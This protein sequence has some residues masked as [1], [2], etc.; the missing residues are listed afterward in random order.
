MKPIVTAHSKLK[1]LVLLALCVSAAMALTAQTLTTIHDIAHV[2]QGTSGGCG[3]LLQATNGDLYGS[4]AG[5]G[6][7]GQ[8]IEDGI[9]FKINLGKTGLGTTTVSNTTSAPQLSVANAP[10]VN[11]PSGSLVQGPSGTLFGNDGGRRR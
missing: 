10:T 9:I 4:G 5:G 2:R 7:G 1:P 11:I 3:A 6:T 8:N